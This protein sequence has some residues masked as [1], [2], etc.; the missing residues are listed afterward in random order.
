[1]TAVLA[2]NFQDDS[3]MH[4]RWGA[5]LFMSKIIANNQEETMK[6]DYSSSIRIPNQWNEW[7]IQFADKWGVSKSYVLRAA[8]KDFMAKQSGEKHAI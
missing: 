7:V 6:K 4:G 8:V 3:F 5:D 2:V 1:M